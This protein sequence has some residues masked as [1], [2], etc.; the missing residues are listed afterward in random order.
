MPMPQ[1]F[2]RPRAY[3]MQPPLQRPG[4]PRQSWYQQHARWRFGPGR[5]LGTPPTQPVSMSAGPGTP[6]PGPTVMPTDTPV[7]EQ[8]YWQA[9]QGEQSPQSYLNRQLG[10]MPRRYWDAYNQTMTG[11]D[12]RRYNPQLTPAGAINPPPSPS[13]R[14]FRPQRFDDPMHRNAREKRRFGVN[15]PGWHSI[16]YNTPPAIAPFQTSPPRW[17]QPPPWAQQQQ[18]QQQPPQPPQAPS[19]PLQPPTPPWF[20]LNLPTQN[21]PVGGRFDYNQP[22][23]WQNPAAMTMADYITDK[24]SLSRSFGDQRA[25]DDAYRRGVYEA[26]QQNHP[27][28]PRSPAEASYGLPTGSPRFSGTGIFNNAI[29]SPTLAGAGFFNDATPRYPYEDE[30]PPLDALPPKPPK[31]TMNGSKIDYKPGWVRAGGQGAA[32]QPGW[33]LD[34]DSVPAWERARWAEMFGRGAGMQKGR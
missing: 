32:P 30:P 8:A 10:A 22:P 4:S 11:M 3:S 7:A 19:S 26:G 33:V 20:Q 12:P 25:V 18:Q 29:S 15:Q 14:Y 6:T 17:Q 16:P 31:A 9:G 13:Q 34:F 5:A 21:Q 24:E 2:S 27:W 23:R 28:Q 1:P